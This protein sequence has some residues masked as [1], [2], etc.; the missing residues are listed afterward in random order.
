MTSNKVAYALSIGSELEEYRSEIE[1]V[2]DFVDEYYD[3]VRKEE[4]TNVIYYGYRNLVDSSKSAIFSSKFW[5]LIDISSSGLY[6]NKDNNKKLE[7]CILPYIENRHDMLDFDYISIIFF[8]LSRVEERDVVNIDKYSRFKSEDSFSVKHGFEKRAVVDE[9]SLE[10]AKII[11]S[12]ECPRHN[13]VFEFIPTHDIDR[14]KG[15]HYPLEPLRYFL[16]DLIKRHKSFN[17][18]FDRIRSSYLSGEPWRQVYFFMNLAEKYNLTARFFF[19]GPSV[20]TMDSPYVIRY[21][22]L[23]IKVVNKIKSRKHVVG[24]H[25]GYETFDNN[26]KWKSQKNGLESA[27]D[28]KVDVG[29]QHVLRYSASVT[30]KIWSD[31]NM[32]VDYTLAYPELIGFRS[33]T[34][35]EYNSYDLVNRKKLKLRQVNTLMMDT[36]IFGG[37]YQDMDLQ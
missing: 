18:S 28:S 17:K 9:C 26:K 32:K 21:K 15:Y 20:N 19:M 5:S 27:I 34:S 14:L 7:D 6:L 24:F 8:F 23:L 25:P 30:P 29:R 22:K 2:F 3:T 11:R 35:R 1:Y 36:G 4:S 31:N 12:E 13:S 33:G 10:L 37:K 16:G